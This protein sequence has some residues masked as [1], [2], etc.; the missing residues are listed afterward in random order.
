MM[1]ASYLQESVWLRHAL[2]HVRSQQCGH[3]GKRKGD[4]PAPDLRRASGRVGREQEGTNGPECHRE[5]RRPRPQRKCRK[6][7][8]SPRLVPP[9]CLHH[10]P[11][12]CRAKWYA[13]GRVR[14]RRRQGRPLHSLYIGTHLQLGMHCCHQ[15]GKCSKANTYMLRP[16]P[17]GS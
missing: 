10:P 15:T 12:G 13:G 1:P 8:P 7:A 14:Q 2:P 6:P 17:G 5:G 3:K 9:Y 4:A 11:V 16:W